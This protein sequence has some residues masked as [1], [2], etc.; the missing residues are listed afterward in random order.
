MSLTAYR[1][2]VELHTDESGEQPSDDAIASDDEDERQSNR[3]Q[4]DATP[5]SDKSDTRQ[6]NLTKALKGL[7]RIGNN[8]VMD[9]RT[10]RQNMLKSEFSDN[11]VKL[12]SQLGDNPAED[13]RP[14]IVHYRS[15]HRPDKRNKR[16]D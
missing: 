1:K 6:S 7:K 8:G 9:L 15:I 12:T 5:A 11:P 4:Q 3:G 2:V 10:V 16:I 14:Q 13:L